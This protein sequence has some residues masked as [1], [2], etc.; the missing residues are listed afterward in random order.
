MG[1]SRNRE[2]S[3]DDEVD[4]Q[5]TEVARLRLRNGSTTS[6]HR[7]VSDVDHASIPDSASARVAYSGHSLS[8]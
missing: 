6:A 7:L 5:Q 8:K 3:D 1:R 2:F 4:V